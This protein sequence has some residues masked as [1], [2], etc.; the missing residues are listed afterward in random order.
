MHVSFAPVFALVCF[1]AQMKSHQIRTQITT[2]AEGKRTLRKTLG[3]HRVAALVAEREGVSGGGVHVVVADGAVVVLAWDPFL[4]A[5]RFGGGRGC[6]GGLARGAR[7]RFADARVSDV[8]G[9]QRRI[10]EDRFE[11]GC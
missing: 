11:F 5:G 10:C 4:R 8:V 7:V 2:S 9:S 6:G 1:P 3:M